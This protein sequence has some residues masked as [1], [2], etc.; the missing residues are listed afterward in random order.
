M[1][2]HLP[3][4]TI[5]LCLTLLLGSSFSCQ[6]DD[7]INPLG[8]NWSDSANWNHNQLPITDAVFNTGASYGVIFS[9]SAAPNINIRIEDSVSFN[10]GGNGISGN[11]HIENDG[12]LTFRGG[13]FDGDL[14]VEGRAVFTGVTTYLRDSIDLDAYSQMTLAD[15]ATGSG[16]VDIREYASFN[17]N[18]GSRYVG[19]VYF[20]SQEASL[21]V[22]GAG[23]TYIHGEE[24]FTINQA[25]HLQVTGGGSLIAD[26]LSMPSGG[27]VAV[28]GAGSRLSTNIEGSFN[29]VRLS[30]SDTAIAQVHNLSLDDGSSLRLSNGGIVTTNRFSM[31]DSSASLNGGAQLSTEQDARLEE[32]TLYF[33]GGVVSVGSELMIDSGSRVTV[34]EGGSLQA[35][36]IRNHGELNFKQGASLT[37]K[38]SYS[39]LNNV[40]G[41]VLRGSLS[42]R[43]GLSNQGTLLIETGQSMR[44]LNGN[45][46]AENGGVISINRGSM[47]VADQLGNQ[48]VIRNDSGALE[49]GDSLDNN[50]GRLEFFGDA[51]FNG[52]LLENQSGGDIL[53]YTGITSFFSDLQNDGDIAIA[54]EATLRLYGDL[55]GSG[56]FHG[57]GTVEVLGDL[58]PG[59][60]P[61]TLSFGGDL[62][63]SGSTNLVLEIGGTNPGDYDFLD[64]DGKFQAGGILA[65]SFING[66]SPQEGDS[67]QLIDFGQIE[68]TFEEILFLGLDPEQEIM[69]FEQLS[70]HS[71]TL[72]TI[73]EPSSFLLGVALLICGLMHHRIRK[74]S[75]TT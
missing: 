46:S 19:E 11:L 21:S 27:S 7:W 70:A 25:N 15:G 10:L 18:S 69:L 35:D 4:A 9:Q 16:S 36:E 68:G 17:I 6:A 55:T 71:L 2:P 51:R 28:T 64:I 5:A 66:Y 47:S 38:N 30:V 29:G 26:R 50:E 65:V 37:G 49:V 32:S 60:S 44:F 58:L 63:L 33:W 61:G 59:N 8:G 72:S 40:E 62:I 14:E 3:G 41:G 12:A 24:Q 13:M 34:Y 67:W 53:I 31:D 75:K 1:K 22:H 45:A 74:A 48:G 23:S 52:I 20:Q 54:E 43:M 39:T 42:T 57:T 56:D 73:P